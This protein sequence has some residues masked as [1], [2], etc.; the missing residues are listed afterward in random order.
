MGY[1]FIPKLTA[2]NVLYKRLKNESLD[3]PKIGGF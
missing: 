1:E 2:W 3:E